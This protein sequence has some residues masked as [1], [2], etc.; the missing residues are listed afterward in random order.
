[1]NLDTFKTCFNELCLSFD[2]DPEKKQNRLSSY[3]NSKLGEMSEYAFNT[4]LNEAKS[5]LRTSGNKLPSIQ[6]LLQL[7][8]SIVTRTKRPRRKEDMESYE[9]ALCAICGGI[10][11]VIMDA[12]DGSTCSGMCCTCEKG[13]AK[14]EATILGRQC[15]LYTEWLQFGYKLHGFKGKDENVPF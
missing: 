14:A 6:S 8:Y 13:R 12:P 1:M 15:G 9:Q 7:H 5:R 10:G 2:L 3:F 4:M 11:W